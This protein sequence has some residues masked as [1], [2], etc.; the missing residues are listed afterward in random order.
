MIYSPEA[1]PLRFLAYICNPMLVGLEPSEHPSET[2]RGGVT[3][4]DDLL[5]QQLNSEAGIFL[6][7]TT[8]VSEVLYPM[9]P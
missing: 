1:I 9:I 6:P 2:G 7:S 5:Y 4:P 8:G 3:S